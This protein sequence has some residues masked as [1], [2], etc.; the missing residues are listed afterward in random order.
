MARRVHVVTTLEV[1]TQHAFGTDAPAPAGRGTWRLTLHRRA[2]S[3]VGWQTTLVSELPDARGRLLEQQINQPAKLT[4]TLN[5]RGAAA[6]LLQ[7]LQ[8]DVIAWRWDPTSGQGRSLFPGRDRSDGGPNNRTV[9]HGKRHMPRLRRHVGP[10][11]HD[12]RRSL[13]YNNVEQDAVVADLL[14]RAHTVVPSGGVPASF[15]PGSWL[16]LVSYPVNGDGSARAASG[17]LRIRNYAGQ[18]AV[19]DLIAQLGA[20]QGGFDWDVVPSWRYVP[21]SNPDWLRVFYPSQGVARTDPV[22]EYGGAVST[23]TRA[24]D[25]GDYANYFRVIGNNGSA[26]PAAA[27]LYA[28]ASNAGANNVGVTPIGL[29]QDVDQANDVTEVATLQQWARGD[30]NT[31]GVLVPHYT[32]GLRPGVYR[33]GAFNMGDTVPIVVRSGRLNVVSNVRVV[34]LTFTIGDDGQ[35][36]VSVAVGR[37]LTTLADMLAETAADVDALARR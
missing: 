4:F 24:V 2:F 25:S 35:E 36:D 37:P 33:D 28:E 22:L 31:S 34:G 11:L 16:P 23:V 10:P 19:G 8:T 21:G 13:S 12:Q 7:E 15:F 9:A 27:Q 32:L 29:W 20:V 1:P 3:D 14:A 17:V 18:A 6:A 5:G 26:D 30:L